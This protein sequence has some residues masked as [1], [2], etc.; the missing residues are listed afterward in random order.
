MNNLKIAVFFMGLMALGGCKPQ[1]E[2]HIPREGDIVTWKQNDQ[3]IVKAKLGPRREHI[4]YDGCEKCKREFYHP[5]RE[6]Y[7][8]Q[9]PIDYIPKKYLKITTEEAESL[10]LPYS[11]YQL[12]FDLILNNSAVQATDK[13]IDGDDGLDH[14]DQVKIMILNETF[15]N[16]TSD[17]YSLAQISDSSVREAKEW[18]LKYGLDCWLFQKTNSLRCYGN[19]NYNK[20]LGVFF[21]HMGGNWIF[22]ESW[23]P[24]YGGIYVKWRIDKRNLHHWREVDAK[25]WQLIDNWNVSPLDNKNNN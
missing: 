18:S 7:L 8:G 13:F 24:M 20:S 1:E 2:V 21:K 3:L 9:F 15:N 5:D 12:E 17:I 6:H 16:R 10:S 23:E 25:I 22:A 11:N 14:K 19:S 4:R